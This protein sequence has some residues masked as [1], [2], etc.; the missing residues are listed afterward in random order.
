MRRA[1]MRWVTEK[2]ERII[3]SVSELE[4]VAM[5]EAEESWWTSGK[6]SEGRV[7]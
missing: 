2:G 1:A 6:I 4:L 7:R 5:E 3:L